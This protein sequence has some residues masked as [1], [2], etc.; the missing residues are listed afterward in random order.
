MPPGEGFFS[1]YCHLLLAATEP[2]PFHIKWLMRSTSGSSAPGT[3]IHPIPTI[4]LY[5]H[6]KPQLEGWVFGVKNCV[7]FVFPL[8]LS[9]LP[10]TLNMYLLNKNTSEYR[11]WGEIKD[12]CNVAKSQMKYLSFECW[13]Q[14]IYLNQQ[15]EAEAELT[16]YC[17]STK[18][19]NLWRRWSLNKILDDVLLSKILLLQKFFYTQFGYIHSFLIY[20]IF[21][22]L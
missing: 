9:T 10:R 15:T 14:V 13:K 3:Y 6:P 5:S 19:C 17:F 12:Y 1:L 16:L 20:H 22:A 11:R 7:F 18:I 21:S 2:H 8:I 4:L